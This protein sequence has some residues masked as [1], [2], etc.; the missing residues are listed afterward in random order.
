MFLIIDSCRVSMMTSRV[1][2]DRGFQFRESLKANHRSVHRG[3]LHRLYNRT[4]VLALNN[5]LAVSKL[6]ESKKKQTKGKSPKWTAS[7]LP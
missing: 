5:S 4:K 7:H 2:R 1:E 6:K 3:A